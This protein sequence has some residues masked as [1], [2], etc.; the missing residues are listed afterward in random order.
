MAR[1]R[2]L[3]RPPPGLGS[4]DALT[5]P[6]L[7]LMAI[8]GALAALDGVFSDSVVLVGLLAFPPVIAATRVSVAETAL[9]GVFCLSLAIL[10]GLWNQNVGA[11]DYFVRLLVV[12]LGAGTAVWVAGLRVSLARERDGADLLAETGLLLQESWDAGDRVEHIARLAVPDLADAATVDL[13]GRNRSILRSATVARDPEV[14]VAFER[15]RN[16]HP[17]DPDS[18][19]PAA[20]A[21]RTGEMVLYDELPEEMLETFGENRGE[22][23]LIRRTRPSSVMVVPLKARGTV[24]GALS[25]WILDPS[26]AHDTR[27]QNVALRLAHR[28]GLALD[29][30]RL[31]E[32][33]SHIA[34]VLQ[35]ALRP[36]SLP[37]I[38]G[39]ES[40]SRFLA[41][42]AD[43]YEVGGDFYDAFDTGS[44][45]W[46]VVIGD[47][48]GKGPEAAALT[49]LARYTI[50]TASTP[51]SSPS[52]VLL[53]LDESIAGDRPE[54]R[55]CTAALARV[56]SVNG[57]DSAVLTVALGG[58]PPPLALRRNG[59]VDVIG[60]PGTL[61][62]A[63]PAPAVADVDA[64][65][66]PSES[67]VFYTDGLLESR[68]RTKADDPGW[69]A[70]LLSGANGVSADELADQLIRIAIERQGGEPRDD[71]AILVLHRNG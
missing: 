34:H 16:R 10:S 19:H 43:A 61:L 13:C 33:Q 24:L 7:L 48:C 59:R 39:F 26:R 58:H 12:L 2:E 8:A 41:A 20:V 18:A 17:V 65:L 55:F 46:T 1:E 15:M 23:D 70:S 44:G 28:A 9:V 3:I 63:L 36:R 11:S 21:I 22:V 68:D 40:A 4:L 56:H 50:R 42:G 69:L 32:Q 60:K 5:P 54:V 35:D 27:A 25:M 57:S 29:N 38:G 67:L 31:H 62:G 6:T 53:A 71:I 45:A 66:A 37:E 52:E 64:S 51:E 49:A 14:E 30:A 47:V